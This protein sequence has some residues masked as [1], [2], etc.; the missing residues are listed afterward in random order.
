MSKAPNNIVVIN[1]KESK[2][3]YNQSKGEK[4]TFKN[5]NFET[6]KIIAKIGH[7]RTASRFV[8]GQPAE[9]ESDS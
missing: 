1:G 2:I 9:V 4:W 5:S 6:V 3:S 7:I 8:L